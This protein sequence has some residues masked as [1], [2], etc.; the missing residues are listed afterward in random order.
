M[1]YGLKAICQECGFEKK[2]SFGGGMSN[3]TTVCIVPAIN[4][5]TGE[6]EGENILDANIDKE[7]FDFYIDSKMYDGKVMDWDFE[8]GD[9]FL[10]RDKNLCPKCKKFSLDFILNS[11]FD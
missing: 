6:L 5:T 1:G 7:N 8:W 2:V 4:K 3:H 11:L 9:L 10:K